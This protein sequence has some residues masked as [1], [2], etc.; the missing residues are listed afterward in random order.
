LLNHKWDNQIKNIEAEGITLSH[1][2]KNEDDGD[3]YNIRTV[4]TK[5]IRH[6]VLINDDSKLGK[7]INKCTIELLKQYIKSI[8]QIPD[9]PQ[10]SFKK[11]YDAINN[12]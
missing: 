9:K 3:I 6:F 12:R 2:V 7:I 5:Y 4:T 10:N 8:V 11:I 1:D